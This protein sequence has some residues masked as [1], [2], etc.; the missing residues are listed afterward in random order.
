MA[1][2]W[3]SKLTKF[4]K[5]VA[6]NL[7][8]VGEVGAA[9]L[10]GI[11]LKRSTSV[12]FKDFIRRISLCESQDEIEVSM[13]IIHVHLSNFQHCRLILEVRTDIWACV[14]VEG[15][16]IPTELLRAAV[17]SCNLSFL[18]YMIRHCLEL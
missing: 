13:C 10:V 1:S 4:A 15:C 14:S 17:V 5:A 16:L 2:Q 12:S 6:E 18:Q 8:K 3:T 11:P 9:A 7:P